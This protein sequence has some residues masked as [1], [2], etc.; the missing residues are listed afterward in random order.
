MLTEQQIDAIKNGIFSRW[1]ANKFSM[2]RI[3]PHTRQKPP[4]MSITANSCLE[5]IAHPAM[6][7]KA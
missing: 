1:G 7:Q 5:H 2:E 6:V 3:H 4:G